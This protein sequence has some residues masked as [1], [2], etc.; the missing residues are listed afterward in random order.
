MVRNF[1]NPVKVLGQ[2]DLAVALNI[3]ADK[4][5]ESAVKKIEAAGGS[6]TRIEKKKMEA[7]LVGEV[8]KQKRKKDNTK[9]VEP[10]EPTESTDSATD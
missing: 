2:G 8:K 1:K 5:S 3:T 9:P 4:F 6:V 7:R 10:T